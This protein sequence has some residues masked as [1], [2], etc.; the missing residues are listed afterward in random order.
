M[1]YAVPG[2]VRN[3]EPLYHHFKHSGA[4]KCHKH[5]T[6]DQHWCVQSKAEEEEKANELAAAQREVSSNGSS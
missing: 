1:L 2:H 3:K 4:Y 6:R 5:R